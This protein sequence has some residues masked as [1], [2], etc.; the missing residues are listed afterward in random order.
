MKNILYYNKIII[1]IY[2][3]SFNNYLKVNTLPVDSKFENTIIKEDKETLIN[4]NSN[5]NSEI[6][7]IKDDIKDKDP[8]SLED[9]KK[10]YLAYKKAK[11]RNLNKTLFQ[12][13]AISGHVIIKLIKG[14]ITGFSFSGPGSTSQLLS[15]YINPIFKIKEIPSTKFVFKNRTINVNCDQESILTFAENQYIYLINNNNC[16]YFKNYKFDKSNKELSKLEEYNFSEEVCKTLK[17]SNEYL[18]ILM[19]KHKL[20]ELNDEITKLSKEQYKKSFRMFSNIKI[21][22]KKKI[23][24]RINHKYLT[25]IKYFDNLQPEFKKQQLDEAKKIIQ[26]FNIINNCNTKKIKKSFVQK[27]FTFVKNK[28]YSFK[29]L[30]HIKLKVIFK[31]IYYYFTAVYRCSKIKEF[32]VYNVLDTVIFRIGA[33]FSENIIYNYFGKLLVFSKVFIAL[34]SALKNISKLFTYKKHTFDKKVSYVLEGFYQLGLAIG[35]LLATIPLSV[36]K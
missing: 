33:I 23:L 20:D 35:Y 18:N 16:N 24:N 2:L 10:L 26:Q 36:K 15:K 19:T 28:F 7:K 6:E 25:N 1:L 27:T 31:S 5:I 3:I 29:V 13:I 4:S 12:F 11:I 17:K 21:Y 30:K 14:L 9:K 22:L 8:M 32:I 34:F